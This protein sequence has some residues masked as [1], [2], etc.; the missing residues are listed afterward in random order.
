MK[1]LLNKIKVASLVLV[2][3]MTMNSCESWL[4]LYPEG[5]TLLEDYW[6]S[7]DDIE[8]VVATCYLSMMDGK[9]MDRVFV[10]GEL[11]SD[12]IERGTKATAE[13]IDILDVNLQT[14][15]SYNDWAIFYQT[16]NYC[17]TVIYYAPQV[18]EEDKN[19]STS[20]MEAYRAEARAI[21]A[22]CYFYL[23]RAFGDVPLVWQPTIEDS[24]SFA[25]AKTPA[26]EVLNTIVED[27]REALLYAKS[28]YGAYNIAYNVSRFTKQSIRVLLADI[29]LWQGRYAECVEVC[30]EFLAYD[31][32]L[33]VVDITA[34]YNLPSPQ[35]M[36]DRFSMLTSVSDVIFATAFNASAMKAPFLKLFGFEMKEPQLSAAKAMVE[37]ADPNNAYGLYSRTDL[38][39]NFVSASSTTTGDY[40]HYQIPK[41]VCNGYSSYGGSISYSTASS[42]F[43]D[44]IFYRLAD[45]YLIRAEAMVELAATTSNEE[46]VT[47]YL[48]HAIDMVNNTYMAANEELRATDSLSLSAY[49]S[50][51]AMRELVLQERRRE[52]IYE[53]KRWFDLV[54][55]AR[56][57]NDAEVLI[58]YF[59]NKRFPNSSSQVALNKM[60][61]MDAL[62]MPIYQTEIDNNDL[63][64]QNPFYQMDETTEKNE[65]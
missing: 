62:Y 61:T 47:K 5:E 2:A 41:Y 10:W 46:D 43:V 29:L 26:N 20:T 9:F 33:K 16:I 65:K 53:G 22:M 3:I 59:D 58:E 40:T 4:E 23:V 17:N 8:S 11:R 63:L 44:W 1:K 21:R 30:D 18:M 64:V 38:R 42:E 52:F 34:G 51:D 13:Q 12:N 37:E 48:N 7:A 50:V 54:R 32:Q 60:S 24:E 49:N 56:K 25:I 36:L 39:R 45:V 14:T 27:L 19:L 15:N 6:K 57:F 28:T 55:H 31:R 35:I